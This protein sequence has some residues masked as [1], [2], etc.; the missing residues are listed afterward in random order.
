MNRAAGQRSL[1]PLR[2][3]TAGDPSLPAPCPGGAVTPLLGQDQQPVIAVATGA[4]DGRQADRRP[5]SSAL[6]PQHWRQL[7]LLCAIVVAVKIGSVVCRPMAVF[8][9]TAAVG[10]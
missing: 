9:A 8:S 10:Q 4:G 7:T 5:T 1:R 6:L 3:S 2:R